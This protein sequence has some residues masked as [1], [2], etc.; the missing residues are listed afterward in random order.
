MSA[1]IVVVGM[2]ITIETQKE[3]LNLYAGH[4][5]GHCIKDDCPFF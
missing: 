2:Y 1:N 3:S 5:I 4:Y